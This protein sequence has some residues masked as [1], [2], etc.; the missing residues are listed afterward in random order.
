MS[1][2]FHALAAAAV[3]DG[4]TAGTGGGGGGGASRMLS[5]N[6]GAAAAAATASAMGAVKGMKLLQY[7]RAHTGAV[8]CAE[9]SRKGQ[10]LATGGAD[11]L[12]KIW[13]IG[14]PEEDSGAPPNRDRGRGASGSPPPRFIGLER[15]DSDVSLASV[16]SVVSVANTACGSTFDCQVAPPVVP[17]GELVIGGRASRVM[18]GH[19]GDVVDLS[20]SPNAFLLSAGR[21][22]S[23]RLWHPGR[24]GCVHLFPQTGSATPTSCAFHPRLENSFATAGEDGKV[25]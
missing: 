17:S 10:Y 18:R 19:S 5:P 11:G 24:L 2:G 3:G 20:W 13:L 1:P 12:V 23:L 7:F 14:A 22:G 6:A 16:A 25:R 21:D 8:W 4:P 9:F 15:C